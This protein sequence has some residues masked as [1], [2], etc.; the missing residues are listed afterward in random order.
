M[1]LLFDPNQLAQPHPALLPGL[2]SAFFQH[3]APTV[4]IVAY[5]AIVSNFL[6]S[7]LAPPLANVI[8]ALAAPYVLFL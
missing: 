1:P 7:R 6:F 2:I 4:P 8:A 3:V 5:E